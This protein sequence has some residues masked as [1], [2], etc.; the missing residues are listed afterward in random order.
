VNA[1]GGACPTA[2]A[3]GGVYFAVLT[4]RA[5]DDSSAPFE[6]RISG[7]AVDGVEKVRVVLKDGTSANASVDRNAFRLAVSG[8]GDQFAA[9]Q[10]TTKSGTISHTW[11]A[12]MFP[13][14]PK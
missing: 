10:L 14:A 1:D 4:V 3:P 5:Y 8:T 2:Y 12:D 6:T 13:I 7:I 9:Y 11:P